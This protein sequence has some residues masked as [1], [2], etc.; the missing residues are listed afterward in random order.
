MATE[1][2]TAVFRV[3]RNEIRLGR[4]PP[5]RPGI[6][7]CGVPHLAVG[8]LPFSPKNPNSSFDAVSGRPVCG[9]FSCYFCANLEH[10]DA[11]VRGPYHPPC[12]GDP[13][14]CGRISRNRGGCWLPLFFPDRAR[15]CCAWA[16]TR[17]NLPPLGRAG[18]MK[19]VIS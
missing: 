10:S 11:R 13:A 5:P 3:R 17:P 12:V 4:P 1:I 15:G 14:Q 8:R 6:P 7:Y 18:S 9:I 16:R 19:R 2:E